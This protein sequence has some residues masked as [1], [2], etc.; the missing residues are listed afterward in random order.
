MRLGC[1]LRIF[2]FMCQRTADGILCAM[3]AF[4]IYLLYNSKYIMLKV[5]SLLSDTVT[6]K[7][8]NKR[9]AVF[10]LFSVQETAQEPKNKTSAKKNILTI[11][12]LLLAAGALAVAGWLY[13]NPPQAKNNTNQTDVSEKLDSILLSRKIT[14]I[15]FMP[16]DIS[17]VFYTADAAGNITY[18]SFDGTQYNEIAPTGEFSL[19][20]SLSN[21][22]IPVKIPYIEQDGTLT[23]FGVFS[24]GATG[25][26]VYIYNFV[27]FKVC[28]LPAA[29]A[30][31]GKC[32]LLA[33]TD[34]T[35]AYTLDPVWEEAY[36]LN[37]ANG[38]TERFLSEN[39]RMLG[40]NG[41]VRSDFCMI[42]DTALSADTAAL[43]F[44]SGRGYDLAADME[45]KSDIYVKN[46]AKETLAVSGVTDRYVKPLGGD[47][48]AFLRKK[49]NGFDTVKYEN[50]TESVITSFY[51]GY[52]SSYIRSGDYLLSKE[53]GRIYTTYDTSVIET[54]GY[55]MN[56]LVFAV[57]PDGK[58]VVMAGTVANAL[59]YRIYVYNT[60]TKKY[61][62][63]T[64]TNY[65]AHDNMRFIDD[66]TVAYYVVNV[67]GYEN[68][69]LDVSKVK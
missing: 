39:N 32:L 68:V 3:L 62:T 35:Q 52:G 28:N 45:N 9:K 34:Q 7:Y 25:S 66:H 38:T 6:L 46:G 48:F 4:C 15:P 50:G 20:V 11:L 23:G 60:E 67:E 54:I 56:P 14:P 8:A 69:V 61:A 49:G 2:Y 40:I 51:A 33:F 42:T 30:A 27:I 43:P 18:Y 13:M 41:A 21:Q 37:R 31:D 57:S 53:D 24:S 22:Q 59:D 36:I 65:A 26:D 17:S 16:T 55:K 29:Y 64:E 10:D 19:S 1:V 5:T 12:I 63:F 58:Y 44:L 47:S